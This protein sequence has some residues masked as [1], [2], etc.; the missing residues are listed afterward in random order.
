MRTINTREGMPYAARKAVEEVNK[1]IAEESGKPN[2]DAHRL[3]KM[4]EER[5][6]PGLF[7]DIMGYYERFRNPW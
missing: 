7:S 5:Y 2:P 4:K 1:K 3:N 6:M